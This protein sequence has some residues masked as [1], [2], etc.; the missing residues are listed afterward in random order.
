VVY[1]PLGFRR[2]RYSAL[3]GLTRPSALRRRADRR[4]HQDTY[5]AEDALDAIDV[6]YIPLPATVDP[7]PEHDVVSDRDFRYGQPEA[8]FATAPHRIASTA[9]YPRNDCT[10]SEYFVVAEGAEARC[11]GQWWW[12]EASIWTERMVSA[13]GDGVRVGKW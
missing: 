8:A 11:H 6:T 4:R 3:G 1:S 2:G 7:P 12:T 13:L 9:D 5:R 10:P